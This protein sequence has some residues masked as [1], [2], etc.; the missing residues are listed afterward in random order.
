LPQFKADIIIVM[1]PG[2]EG[3][4]QTRQIW[5]QHPI[6]KSITNEVQQVHFVDGYLWGYLDGPIAAE[7][8]IDDLYQH[9]INTPLKKNLSKEASLLHD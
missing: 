6:L 8:L 1:A 5:E 3:L 9:L 7:I 2:T 4:R